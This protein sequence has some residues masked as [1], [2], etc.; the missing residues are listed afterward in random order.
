MVMGTIAPTLTEVNHIEEFDVLL[1]IAEAAEILRWS[2]DST[3]RYFKDLPGVLVKFQPRRYKRPYRI[4]MIPK[5]VFQR[6]W[7]RMAGYNADRVTT[8]GAR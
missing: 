6:E 4:Y 7:E 1:T 2:Y 3:R 8:R 5:A